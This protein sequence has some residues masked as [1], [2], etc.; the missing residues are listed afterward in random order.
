MLLNIKTIQASV[1]EKTEKGKVSNITF[2]RILGI[3]SLVFAIPFTAI[4]FSIPE[5]WV[6]A[7]LFWGCWGLIF[8]M[9]RKHIK[10]LKNVKEL[11]FRLETDICIKK[12]IQP[13]CDGSFFDTRYICCEKYG[14]KELH[15][16]FA[17]FTSSYADA[18]SGDEFYL[19]YINNKLI[20]IFNKKDWTL[21][22]SQFENKNGY[23]Y[24]IK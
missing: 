15:F 3:I 9:T 1:G 24:P 19:L 12:Y 2:A 11:K 8:F 16:P 18:E 10:I 22:M 6:G 4:S 17:S 7:A 23:F 5:F 20:N 13:S 21:D 14:Q